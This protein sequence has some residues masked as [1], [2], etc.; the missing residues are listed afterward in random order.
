MRWRVVLEK[1]PEPPPRPSV[2]RLAL[3]LAI[4]LLLGAVMLW[5]MGAPPWE[6]YGAMALLALI[7]AAAAFLLMR[8]WHGGLVVASI[9]HRA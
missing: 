9:A 7:G 8:R 3:A 4:G 5:L 1:R 2:A 6:A